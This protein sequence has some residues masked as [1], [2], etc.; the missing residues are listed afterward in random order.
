LKN[1]RDTR[2]AFRRDSASPRRRRAWIL[3]HCP[4]DSDMV[5]LQLFNRPQEPKL[6]VIRF[7]GARHSASEERGVETSLRLLALSRDAAQGLVEEI[8]ELITPDVVLTNLVAY[9]REL[10]LEPPENLPD[11]LEPALLRPPTQNVADRSREDGDGDSVGE[12]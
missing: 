3:K 12:Q 2:E 1:A 6:L 11:P 7:A 9:A 5:R 4:N 10:S 8:L